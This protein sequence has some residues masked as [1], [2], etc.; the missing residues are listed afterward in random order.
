MD[1]EIKLYNEMM[2]E[3]YFPK[4]KSLLIDTGYSVLLMVILI[5]LIEYWALLVFIPFELIMLS[6]KP[7]SIAKHISVHW[8]RIYK[9]Q[10]RLKG[11]REYK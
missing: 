11:V 6:G 8:N 4:W 9:L 1:K 5:L 7:K 2:T 10:D 3:A